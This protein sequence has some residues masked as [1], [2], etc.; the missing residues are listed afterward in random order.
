MALRA[1]HEL[2]ANCLPF[3]IRL[4]SAS[5]IIMAHKNR[6]FLAGKMRKFFPVQANF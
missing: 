6:A 5:T 3:V 1:Q 4:K 2:Q